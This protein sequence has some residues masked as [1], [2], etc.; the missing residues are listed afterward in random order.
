MKIVQVNNYCYIRGGS[1]KVFLGEIEVLSKLGHS[2]AVFSRGHERNLRCDF[3]TFFPPD[4]KDEG[5]FSR[6]RMFLEY[7]YSFRVYEAFSSFINK[8]PPDVVHLHNIYGRLTTSV[9]DAARKARVPLVLTAHDYKLVCPTYLMLN[10][11]KPCEKC[12]Q[13]NYL[14]CVVQ[15]CHH[16]GFTGSL[17]YTMESYFNRFFKKYEKVDYLIAPSN[18]LRDKLINGGYSHQ[19]VVHI[20]N[21]VNT[22]G[23]TPNFEPGDYIVYIGRVSGEKGIKTLV[24]AVK[25]TKIQAKIVGEG[26]L[27]KWLQGIIASEGIPNIILVGYKSGDDLL[28]ILRNSAF[29]VLPSEW[30]ENAPLSILEAY[31][32]GKPVVA[33]RIGGI[34]EM[35]LDGVTGFLFEPGNVEQLKEIMVSLYNN[36]KLIAQ[37]GKNARD[38][39]ER[40]YSPERHYEMLMD[41]YEKAIAKY[42]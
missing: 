21:F 10:K 14:N 36:K 9:I 41:I 20:P 2:V 30:Y 27:S 19:K 3:S 31:A 37:M 16:S 15:N 28:D 39:V 6:V 1:E 8:F 7:I 18:F 42:R 24:D 22:S 13:G 23:I 34:P 11:G 17:L 5:T 33:S 35:V 40:E 32:C 26:P 4:I 12:L 38:M 29:M 25:T